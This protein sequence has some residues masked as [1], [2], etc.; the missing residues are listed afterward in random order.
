MSGS[1]YRISKSV[2]IAAPIETVFHFHD[3]TDNLLRITP[4]HI[5]VQIESRGTPGLGYEVHLRVRQF[6]LLT[7][8]WHVRITEY[9]APTRMVDEQ[10]KGP[11]AIWRQIRDLRPIPG[12]TELR[13]TVEYAVP[14]GI[15]GRLANWLVIRREIERMFAYRQH[16]TKRLL[17]GTVSALA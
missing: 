10:V 7:M 12:G 15:L 6:G 16:A 2:E 1:V 13:D 3:N 11:F 4:P 9:V 14:F 8:H 17:E 5:K